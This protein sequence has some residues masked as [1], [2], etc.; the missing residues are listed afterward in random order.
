[1]AEVAPGRTAVVADDRAMSY[2][3]LVAET[4]RLGSALHRRGIADGSVVSTDLTSGP[5]LFAL[6][7]AALKHGLGILPISA[8]HLA[9]PRS[10]PLLAGLDVRLHIGDMRPDGLPS[11]DYPALRADT[12]PAAPAAAREGFLVYL[13]SGTTGVPRTVARARPW[14]RHKGVAVLPKYGAGPD[15]GPHL[16]A[17]PTFHLGTLG[18][19]LYALQAGAG[20]IVQTRWSGAGFVGLVDR[21]RVDSA[22]VAPN[23]LVDIASGDTAPR[24][25]PK[26]VFHGGSACPPAV[27]RRAIGL[28][29]PI[30]H[31]YYGTSETVATEISSTEWLRRP[32]SVGR[33]LPGVGLSIVDDAGHP[34][35]AG[36]LGEVRITPRPV[37]RTATGR[38]VRTGDLG[39]LD[40]DGYLYV[41]G[42]LTATGDRRL[43]RLAHAVS[44]LPTVTDIAVIGGDGQIVCLVESGEARDPALRHTIRAMAAGFGVV[45]VRVV[46]A[47][48]GTFPRTPSGKIRHVEPVAGVGPP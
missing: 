1:M 32:G 46:V 48:H 19:A 4:D 13:T 26:V 5:S 22:F 29:G 30:L 25:Y 33:A 45:P 36:E 27:K 15:T 39:H 11:V 41:V 8:E 18:P 37:N 17:N 23:Q 40:D 12:G 6:V 42:R 43:A 16:M 9:D 10:G 44:G 28:L 38:S 35:P 24:H 20:V 31:E 3:E 2:A 7:L 14:Y 21:Y 47:P 34:V